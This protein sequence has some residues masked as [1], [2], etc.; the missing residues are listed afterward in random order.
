MKILKKILLG[1]VLTL[2]LFTVSP[3][4]AG[5]AY[6]ADSI[7]PDLDS[8]V[9]QYQLGPCDPTEDTWYMEG[10]WAELLAEE[11]KLEEAFQNNS[12]SDLE[13]VL[14]CA[15]RTGNINFWMVKYFAIYA[16]EFLLSLGALIA[17]LMIMVGAYYYIAGGLTD[18]KEKGKTII[19]YAIGGLVLTS[20][21]WVIVNVIL[22]ALTS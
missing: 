15:M 4:I 1:A 11:E 12:V 9:M 20:L 3:D 8:G 6:A 10:G 17:I 18:D 16:L 14:A 21:S 2:L 13:D 19:T 5:K 22:L 7:L